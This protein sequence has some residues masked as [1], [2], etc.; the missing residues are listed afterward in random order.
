M[1]K[2][3]HKGSSSVDNNVN[4]NNESKTQINIHIYFKL[5]PHVFNFPPKNV[6]V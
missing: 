6:N 2:L 4:N 1:L 3:V 5:W